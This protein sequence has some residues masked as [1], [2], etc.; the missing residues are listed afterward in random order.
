MS[1][2]RLRKDGSVKHMLWKF[3]ASALLLADA[4]VALE[5][6]RQEKELMDIFF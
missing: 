6:A 3:E 5:A 2:H 4:D 1:A